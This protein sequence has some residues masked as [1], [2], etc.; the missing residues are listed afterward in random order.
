MYSVKRRSKDG[1]AIE[2]L[3]VTNSWSDLFTMGDMPVSSLDPFKRFS[4]K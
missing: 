3:T 2:E 1:V 4:D